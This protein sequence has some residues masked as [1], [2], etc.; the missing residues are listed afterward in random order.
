MNIEQVAE[1]IEK[2]VVLLG[3]EKTTCLYKRRVNWLAKYSRVSERRNKC[4]MIT[5]RTL[6]KLLGRDMYDVLDKKVKNRQRARDLARDIR[7]AKKSRPFREGTSGRGSHPGGRSR[8]ENSGAETN[9]RT[10]DDLVVDVGAASPNKA[11]EEGTY[12][13]EPLSVLNLVAYQK[14]KVQMDHNNLHSKLHQTV[15]FCHISRIKNRFYGNPLSEESPKVTKP[16]GERKR[17][18]ESG[19]LQNVDKTSRGSCRSKTC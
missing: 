2:T 11:N 10:E 7:P 5:P 18:N 9:R 14:A 3:Q 6:T 17:G 4:F 1:L 16:R 19:N 15:K 13:L 8:S 12:S